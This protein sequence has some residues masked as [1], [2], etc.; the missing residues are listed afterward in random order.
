[1]LCY[2][3]DLREGN[4]LKQNNE[5]RTRV[6]LEGIVM[7]KTLFNMTN[8]ITIAIAITIAIVSVGRF[9]ENPREEPQRL[10]R[11][12][13]WFESQRLYERMARR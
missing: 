1:M 13:S 10:S 2:G 11:T 9:L 8:V 5:Q 4:L 7:D 6:R 12:G 3:I